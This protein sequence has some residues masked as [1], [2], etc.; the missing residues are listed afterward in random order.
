MRS[1]YKICYLLC[2]LSMQGLSKVSSQ[3]ILKPAGVDGVAFWYLTVNNNNIYSWTDISGNQFGTLLNDP[4]KLG[5]KQTRVLTNTR[6]AGK[7]I[8]FHPS[9]VLSTK[10][11]GLLNFKNL[12][13]PQL[14]IIGVL[15]PR[16]QNDNTVLS[17]T[18]KD[19]NGS[20][21]WDKNTVQGGNGKVSLLQYGTAGQRNSF[22]KNQV[23][24]QTNAMKI[25][26]YQRFLA[27]E[28]FNGFRR[29]RDASLQLSMDGVIPELIAFKK[30][31][32]PNEIWRVASNLSIKYGLTLDSSYVASN[33]M[34]LLWDSSDK[35]LSPFHN[36]VIAI[37][38]DSSG[39]LIQPKST[40]TYQEGKPA[41]DYNADGWNERPESGFVKFI[42]AQTSTINRSLIIGFKDSTMNSL[43]QGS[44]LFFGDDNQSLISGLEEADA[45]K[46]PG[47]MAV[48]RKWIAYNKNK[49]TL[50]T[51][52]EVSAGLHEAIYQPYDYLD[53]RYVLIK[54][55]G[56]SKEIDTTLL[57]DHFSRFINNKVLKTTFYNCKIS[58][59]NVGW[60]SRDGSAYQRFSFGKVPLLRFNKVNTINVPFDIYEK[61]KPITAK[62]FPHDRMNISFK[63]DAPLN[64]DVTFTNGVK[65]YKY[66]LV[67]QAAT[68]VVTSSGAINTPGI[69]VPSKNPGTPQ[70][71]EP[72][73]EDEDHIISYSGENESNRIQIPNLSAD[74]NYLLTI[75]DKVNQVITLPL[76]LKVKK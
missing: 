1:L 7:N 19:Y 6:T 69:A 45:V 71:D 75:T 32:S 58:W 37:G 76:I 49:I 44:F 59:M 14:T 60:T 57:F 9:L 29:K 31:L 52:V 8:N 22:I 40:T 11:L 34:E 53:Y 72:R 70:S 74:T 17:L 26:V 54:Y 2:L 38:S 23:T 18:L 51:T 27:P 66:T 5:E 65:P 12:S 50:P 15:Y 24:D 4:E 47:M 33:G 25:G 46:Y 48:K 55:K 28:I 62:E 21:T 3:T 61:D 36:R 42:P 43:K 13:L 35:N 16:Y 20:V 30:R 10:D 64:L 39:N 68:D 67:K 63:K 56:E 73:S 41:I